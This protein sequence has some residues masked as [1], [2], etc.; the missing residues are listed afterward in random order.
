MDEIQRYK[1]IYTETATCDM[2]EKAD[3][4]PPTPG[5]HIGGALGIQRNPD[6]FNQ[7]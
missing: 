5:A 7:Q 4:L 2:E 1:I 3:Y 6:V